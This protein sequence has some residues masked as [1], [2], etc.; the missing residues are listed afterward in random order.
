MDFFDFTYE[1]YQAI[2]LSVKVALICSIISLPIAIGIAWLLPRK[3]FVRQWFIDGVL[4]L[5]S[6]V[7]SLESTLTFQ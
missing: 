6:I 4:Q 7:C 5:V 2:G 3:E 1:E